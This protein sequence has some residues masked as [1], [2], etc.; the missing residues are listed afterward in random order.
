MRQRVFL[1]GATGVLGRRVVPSLIQAGH[2][3]TAV[4]RSEAKAE[5]VRAAGATAVHLD[6]F[7]PAAVRTAIDGHDCVAH[8]A[9]HIPTGPSAMRR[10]AWR[11]NDSL[12]RDAA[13]VLAGAAS[14]AG[15]E[16]YIQESITFPYVDG[17]DQWI[18]ETWKR[19][20]FWG[21]AS[22]VAAE[23]AAGGVTAS[24]GIG[25]VLRFAMFMAPDSAHMRAVLS[26][27]QRGLFALVGAATGH[28]SFIHIDDATSAVAAALEAPAGTYNVAEPDPLQRS[29]HRDAL[30]GLV[31]RARLRAVPAV[32]E[33]VGGETA[34]SLARSHRIS[35]QHLREV[36]RWA[37]EV[38]CVDRWKELL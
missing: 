3:V 24:G 19:T 7:D 28:V 38:H 35:S 21:N 26:A 11:V 33:R 6:L 29:T 10:S 17:G 2:S 15:I 9:T 13:A 23:T 5:A 8:L 4:V 16:R 14:D 37:P 12:R 1:T 31:G 34:N 22:T 18:D 30:A 27:A 20:Y 36:T 32:V 25:I